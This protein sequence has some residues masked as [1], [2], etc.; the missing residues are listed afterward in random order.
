[1]DVVI[2]MWSLVAIALVVLF[3]LK[4]KL[5]LPPKQ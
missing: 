1:M 2:G 5:K 3:L 4:R